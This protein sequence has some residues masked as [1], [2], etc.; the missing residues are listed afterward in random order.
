MEGDGVFNHPIQRLF[1]LGGVGKVGLMSESNRFI[2]GDRICIPFG[3]TPQSLV[4]LVFSGHQCGE[5]CVNHSG[6][7]I[8]TYTYY[9]LLCV[10]D[11]RQYDP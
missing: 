5:I 9:T 6:A 3:F 7:Y 8:N 1:N 11:I 4:Y 2:L 10:T